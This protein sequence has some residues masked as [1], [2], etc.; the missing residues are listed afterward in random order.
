MSKKKEKKE[1]SCKNFQKRG[2]RRNKISKN[3]KKQPQDQRKIF[4]IGKKL[5]KKQFSRIEKWR[6]D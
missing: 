1:K 6:Q 4:K 3:K 5:C 2:F